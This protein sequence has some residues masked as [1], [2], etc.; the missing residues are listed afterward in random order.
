MIKNEISW[1]PGED[2]EIP[3][4]SKMNFRAAN[5]KTV[6]IRRKIRGEKGPARESQIGRLK[7]T[8]LPESRLT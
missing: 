1:P 7:G 6:H 8:S 3:R 5:A 2:G 4:L